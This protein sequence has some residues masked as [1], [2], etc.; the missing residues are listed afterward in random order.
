M[1][2]ASEVGELCALLR[3]VA[4]SEADGFVRSP[5]HRARIEDE[6]ADIGICLLMFCDRADIDLVPTMRRKIETNEGWYLVD[7]ARGRAERPSAGEG[8]TNR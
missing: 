4:G 5:E 8:L 3:W 2:L 6:V 1:A 7:Q